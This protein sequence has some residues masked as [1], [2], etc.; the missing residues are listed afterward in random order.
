ME[1]SMNLSDQQKQ[2]VIL[3]LDP[4]ASEG[5]VANAAIA[6]FRSLRAQA[7]DGYELLTQ[8]TGAPQSERSIYAGTILPFKKYRGARL[9]EVPIDYLLWL[10]DNVDTMSRSLRKAIERFLQDQ[11]YNN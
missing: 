6:F 11:Q 2:F 5:E 10:L 1:V 8:L 7:V 9:D 3:S 4:A